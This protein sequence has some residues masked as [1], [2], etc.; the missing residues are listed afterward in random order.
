[1]KLLG[2][3]GLCRIEPR[4]MPLTSSEKARVERVSKRYAGSLAEA[5]DPYVCRVCT[6]A[7]FFNPHCLVA[8]CPTVDEP[9]PIDVLEVAIFTC[10]DETDR[11]HIDLFPVVPLKFLTISG[12]I[13]LS[14]TNKAPSPRIGGSRFHYA[15]TGKPR[16]KNTN[17]DAC[18][19]RLVAIFASNRR[20]AQLHGFSGLPPSRL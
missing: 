5:P 2:A 10:A 16:G 20:C 17:G 6:C 4:P 18:R 9:L 3:A 14:P 15:F 11:C 19:I 7:L 13:E 1:M 12:C 8:L